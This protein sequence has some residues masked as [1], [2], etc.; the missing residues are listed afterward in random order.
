MYLINHK[1]INIIY[2]HTLL[3]ESMLISPFIIPLLGIPITLDAEQAISRNDS[4]II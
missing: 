1:F 2:E 3:L 4:N